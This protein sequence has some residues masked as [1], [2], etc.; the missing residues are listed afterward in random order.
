MTDYVKVGDLQV[1]K[2]L[3]DFINNEAIP[4][5]GLT[6]EAFWA[7]ADRLIHDLAG[8]NRALLA[9]RDALQAAVD[10]WHQGRQG[11]PHDP[12]AYKA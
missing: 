3:R 10:A 2:V 4:G 9:R 8:K 12:A 7:G 5:S 6:A 1:A 11:Q